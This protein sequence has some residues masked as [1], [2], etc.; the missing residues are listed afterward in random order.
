MNL[1]YVVKELYYQRRRTIIS[2]LG[3]SIGIALFL[4]LNAL[5]L[6]YREAARAPLKE[7]GADITVQRPGNVPQELTGAVF[8]CSAVTIR[9]EEITKIEKIPGII[10]TGKAVLVWVF[11]PHRAWIVLVM[12]EITPSV[13]QS[14]VPL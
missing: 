6:A 12:K 5:S 2:V 4:I 8:P 3:L 11:D 10:G 13:R 14:F 1:H 7:I 9:Q